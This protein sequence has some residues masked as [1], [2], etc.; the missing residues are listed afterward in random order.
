MLA[1]QHRMRSSVDFQR[2]RRNGKK[3][4]FAG[5][6]VHVYS[7]MYQNYPTQVGLTVGKD[8]GNSVQRHRT[9]RRIRA[10]ISAVVPKLPPGTG[11]V[12]KALPEI[13]LVRLDADLITE[14][15]LTKMK[16]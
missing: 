9:S 10:A 1:A 13:H 2:V 14:S 5:L 12:V 6:V 15:L 3:V 11:M 4:V 8:C 16:S 7:G